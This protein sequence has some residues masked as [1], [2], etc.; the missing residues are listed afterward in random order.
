MSESPSSNPEVQGLSTVKLVEQIANETKELAVGEL[1][2]A[3]AELKEDLKHEISTAKGLGAAGL[4]GI[5]AFNTLLTTLVLALA[6]VWPG[7]VAGLAVT[8]VVTVAA[9]VI[10]AWSWAHRIKAPLARTRRTVEEDVQ[11]AK[12]RLA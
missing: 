6:Q 7:W 10:G 5:G 4:F 3:K 11:W 2:L 1:S 8:G 9:G 12:N